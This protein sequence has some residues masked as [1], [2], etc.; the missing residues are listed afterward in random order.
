MHLPES[1]TALAGF[2]CP[3]CDC[4][5]S[6]E[7]CPAGFREAGGMFPFC[8]FPQ[9]WASTSWQRVTLQAERTQSP[10]PVPGEPEGRGGL[11]CPSTVTGRCVAIQMGELVMN[12]GNCSSFCPVSR[13]RQKLLL[14]QQTM[15]LCGRQRPAAC[16]GPA[17]CKPPITTLG[18]GATAS[19]YPSPVGNP[20]QPL[21]RAG[22]GGKATRAFYMI[23][24]QASC[25]L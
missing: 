7:S 24:V 22:E 1:R 23:G 20:H 9:K 3:T 18:S 8:P 19:G 16:T 17:L 25:L 11:P 2:S 5:N 12:G 21:S 15:P 13:R 14:P 4:A 10:P 6:L